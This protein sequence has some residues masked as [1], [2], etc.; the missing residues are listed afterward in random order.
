LTKGDWLTFIGLIVIAI[1][2]VI[3]SFITYKG[4]EIRN[5]EREAEK[6]KL[7][8]KTGELKSPEF[9]VSKPIIVQLGGFHFITNFTEL[10]EGINFKK[11]VKIE[12]LTI[13]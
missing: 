3:G 5:I 7:E 11:Y 12:V 2:T 4:Q 6:E 1:G 8:T 13:Q 9:D 10:K